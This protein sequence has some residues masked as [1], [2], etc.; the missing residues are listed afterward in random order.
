MAKRT[1]QV[2]D[3]EIAAAEARLSKQVDEEVRQRLEGTTM[4]ADTKARLEA[5]DKKASDAA[6]E[7]AALKTRLEALEKCAAEQ[8]PQAEA[9]K[10]RLEAEAKAQ[11]AETLR[12][13]TAL[14]EHRGVP[15]DRRE[16]EAK[17]LA[18][19]GHA[20]VVEILRATPA[21]RADPSRLTQRREA[22]PR[23]VEHVVRRL[24]SHPDGSGETQVLTVQD[25]SHYDARLKPDGT[26]GAVAMGGHQRPMTGGG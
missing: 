6:T 3:A 18:G 11:D 5:A 21:P 9:L 1:I 17:R 7:A 8:K 19:L 24:E 13:A 25:W 22:A 4:D 20:A 26:P 2:D 14:A 10:Q 15:V 12:L 16:A 23:A